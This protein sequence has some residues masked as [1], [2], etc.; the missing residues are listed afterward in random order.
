[1]TDLVRLTNEGGIMT[2]TMLKKANVFFPEMTAA[3]NAALDEAEAIA[4]AST[5]KAGCALVI[6]GNGKFFSAGFD[7]KW[8]NANRDTAGQM[9]VDAKTMLARL[10]IF[11]MPTIAL[12][13]GHAFGVGFF[14]ALCCDYR[15][16]SSEH[17]KLCTPELK[18]G[19]VLSDGFWH[20]FN[21]K[22]T[23]HV[24]RDA[25]L[26][27]HQYSGQEAL[28]VGLTDKVAPHEHLASVARAVALER[29]PM[30]F[31]K[32]SVYSEL[33]R[34]IWRFGHD[35]LLMQPDLTQKVTLG[36]LDQSKL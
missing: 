1:M 32:G 22:S 14:L 9:I 7:L 12:I 16:Q 30:A 10:L 31:K 33:K 5:N 28:E 26:M 29:A 8:I 24:M 15:V 4:H 18:I 2:L 25:V 36:T 27:A 13:N 21:S 35:G 17:G 20:V 6:A 11:P 23:P 3:M 34:E 19:S